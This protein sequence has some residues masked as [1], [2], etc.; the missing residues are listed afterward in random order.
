[1]LGSTTGTAGSVK[2]LLKV[3]VWKGI[4]ITCVPAE[5]LTAIW[6]T[7]PSASGKS[8]IE[9]EEPSA[10]A[11]PAT[12]VPRIPIEATGVLT[13]IASSPNLATLPETKEKTPLTTL[14]E[15]LPVFAP[16]S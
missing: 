15:L 11:L 9:F 4:D 12:V 7:P 14:N 8:V 6:P 5:L 3:V 1:L 2:A 16:G 10:A 13:T